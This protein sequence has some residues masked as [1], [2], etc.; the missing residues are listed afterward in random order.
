MQ[1]TRRASVAAAALALAVLRPPG[2]AANCV[3]LIDDLPGEATDKVFFPNWQK[4]QAAA[5][6][7]WDSALTIGG[8]CGGV[9]A[10]PGGGC[11]GAALQLRGLTIVNTGTA[12]AGTDITA[13]YWRSDADAAGV[14]HTM[15]A[16]GPSMWT[17]AWNGVEANPDMVLTPNLRI[18]TDIAPSPTDG[19]SVQLSIPVDI[20][21]GTG[22]LTDLGCCDNGG[23]VH[24]AVKFLYAVYKEADKVTAAPGET[25]TYTLYYGRP[26]AGSITNLE[27]IDTQPP[28]THYVAGSAS[29]APDPGWDPDIGP[30]PRLK[31]TFPG[32]LPV[33]GGPTGSVTFQLTVDWGNTESFEPGSGDVAAPEGQN[34]WNQATGIFPNLAAGNK[35]HASN[36]TRTTIHRFMYWMV[37]D[38]DILF[39]CSPIA[40]E[41]ATYSLFVKNVSPDRTWWNVN[42]WDTVPPEFDAWQPGYGFDD[43]CLGW[44]MTPS[45]C[46]AATPGRV[47]AGGNTILTW[48]LDMPPGYTIELRWKG[49]VRPSATAGGT[50]IN[51]ISMLELGSAG[52]F[53]GTGHSTTPANFTHLATIILRT[54]YV[55]YTSYDYNSCFSSGGQWYFITFYPLHPSATWSLYYLAGGCGLNASITNT[56]P[57]L[58]CSAWPGPG[59]PVGIERV[60]Q[61]YGASSGITV[62]ANPAYDYYKLV[63]NSPVLWEAMPTIAATNQDSV[64]YVPMTTRSFRGY[65]GY[66]WRRSNSAQTAQTH[67]DYL[68]IVNTEN[69]PTTVHLFQWNPGSLSWTHMDTRDLD[70]NSQWSTG[71][72]S[73]A[74]EGHWRLLSSDAQVICWEGYAYNVMTDYDNFTTMA[75]A[76]NGNLV[77]GSGEE[78]YAY[79]GTRANG[80]V[81]TNVGT[82][83]ATVNLWQYVSLEPLL[84]TGFVPPNLGGASGYWTPVDSATIPPGRVGAIPTPY[85]SGVTGDPHTY[86]TNACDDT[87]TNFTQMF[88][89]LKIRVTGG[90]IQVRTGRGASSRYGGYVLHGLDSGGNSAQSVNS[91]WHSQH[92][93]DPTFDLVAFC[94]ASGMAVQLVSEDGY[95]A[96]YTTNGPDQPITFCAITEAA[97]SCATNYRGIVLA[98]A[99]GQVIAMQNG[100]YFTERA[101]TAPFLATGTHYTI[102]APPTVFV[103]Q[104]FWITV[105]VLDTSGV[106]KTN[107]TGTTSFTSTDPSAKI[108][109]ANMDITNYTWVLG[110]AGVKLFLNVTLTRLG[111]QTIVASDINDGS[112]TG[113]TSVMVVGAD[114]KLYK[115][116][117]LSV[118]ASG[119]TV[120]FQVCWSN[121]SSASAFSFV[122]TDAL[123]VG[124]SFVPEAT[125]APF[126][127][128]NTDGQPVTV[129]Y[130]TATSVTPPPT[131]TTGN[132]AAGTRWLR[133][134]VPMAGI[135]TTGCGCFRVSVN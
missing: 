30:P 31:W 88:E 130:S 20:P 131:F 129:S 47:L 114:V 98:P 43:P 27:L 87:T 125:T 12:V 39:T 133:W 67:G 95:N 45:G 74:L 126:D 86:S 40:C 59:C 36:Q 79:T 10:C 134:T 54:T 22:G 122:I 83:A 102:I 110:D 103:G 64:W 63:A 58:P 91:F 71:G 23:A 82:V 72:T 106:T 33:T 34:L 109:G 75:P 65:M 2:V 24:S 85:V 26:G 107:Y 17:W 116:P 46:A 16:E 78:F 8:A 14:Y 21:S 18:Y 115:F 123:P 81:M 56:A 41:E 111:M 73:P 100:T 120:Q 61:Y 76:T 9:P 84:T 77:A 66:T 93:G 135:G 13:M 70:P 94:P 121:Y 113:L 4:A 53:Q 127:C 132:P 38:R 5:F 50:A 118:A 80:F 44:T 35:A 101:Y 57:A 37:A 62:C 89:L 96:T 60:P 11:G 19:A 90:P 55:S 28:Y 128:G 92:L 3:A 42:V 7:L 112:I 97:G 117:K 68:G 1:W 69:I 29:P 104:S 105:V 99:G 51:R 48:K 108:L 119:D 124:T 32:P 25:I 52:K 15:T 49:S 6:Y